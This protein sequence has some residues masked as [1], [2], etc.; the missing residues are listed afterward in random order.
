M[1]Q[2]RIQASKTPTNNNP[3]AANNFETKSNA[4]R[5]PSGLNRSALQIFKKSVFGRESLK[6]Y[7]RSN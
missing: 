2:I 7:Q 6:L 3:P 5:D 4:G 1:L